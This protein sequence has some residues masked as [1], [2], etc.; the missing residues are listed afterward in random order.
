VGVAVGL[1]VGVGV[2]VAVG[3]GL[4]VGHGVALGVGVGAPLN[5]L[6]RS[7]FTICCIAVSLLKS[8][9]NVHQKTPPMLPGKSKEALWYCSATTRLA[10]KGSVWLYAHQNC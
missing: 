9:I 7:V 5:S 6:S 1:G 4:T 10:T 8:V 3:V 2:G